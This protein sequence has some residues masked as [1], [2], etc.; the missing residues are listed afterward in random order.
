MHQIIAILM[1]LLFVVGTLSAAPA[2]AQPKKDAP[3]KSDT[4]AP[5]K[6]DAKKKEPLDLNTATPSQLEELP[7]IG[8]AY[9]KKIID[10]RPYKSK[11]ELVRKNV[12]PESTYE[13]IRDQVV[14]RQK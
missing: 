1:A 13:K 11:D 14:A 9:A 6:A 5:A 7:D 2:F 4:K 3:A 12:L 10:N 8:P